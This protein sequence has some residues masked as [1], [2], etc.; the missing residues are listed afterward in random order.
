MVKLCLDITIDESMCVDDSII[1][2]FLDEKHIVSLSKK[3]PHFSCNKTVDERA[4]IVIER[5]YLPQETNLKKGFFRRIFSFVFFLLV[6]SNLI[7]SPFEQS[8]ECEEKFDVLFKNPNAHIDISCFK[9]EDNKKIKFRLSSQDCTYDTTKKFFISIDEI[10][11]EYSERKRMIFYCLFCTLV[12]NVL[13]SII[14]II[15]SNITTLFFINLIF[16]I[17]LSSCLFS[18]KRLR[19]TYF[20]ILSNNKISSDEI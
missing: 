17:I 5:K 6:Q 19:E 10:T 18:F 11:N 13:V 16:L 3:T 2:V 14:S 7:S 9:N 12:V 8:F 1:N 4:T 15:N 20:E